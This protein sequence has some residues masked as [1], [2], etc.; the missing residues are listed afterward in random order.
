MAESL[1]IPPTIDFTSHIATLTAHVQ[2]NSNRFMT[3]ED[4]N[5][6]L[7]LENRTLQEQNQWL[8][9]MEFTP[10]QPQDSKFRILVPPM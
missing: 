8:S 2:E 9:A 1:D 10:Q 6:A 4:E 3:L 7:H 5:M